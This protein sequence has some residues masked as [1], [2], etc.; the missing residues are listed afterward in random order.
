MRRDPRPGGARA[1]RRGAFCTYESGSHADRRVRYA[2]R[3]VRIMARLRTA[4]AARPCRR[5]AYASAV[6][7]AA[8]TRPRRPVLA[9]QQPT[10]RSKNMLE[11]ASHDL[12]HQ[13]I[14]V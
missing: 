9:T 3:Y 10:H 8:R 4:A 11:H 14:Y 5:R 7:V 13:V 2:S 12:D 1:R 6:G